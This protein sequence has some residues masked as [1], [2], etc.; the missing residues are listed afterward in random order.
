MLGETIEVDGLVWWL[1]VILLVVL[2]ISG[3]RRL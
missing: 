3:I 2:I 1:I